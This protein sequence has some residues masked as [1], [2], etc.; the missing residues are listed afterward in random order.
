LTHSKINL[1]RFTSKS[2]Y[3]S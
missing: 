3:H 1:S 2:F